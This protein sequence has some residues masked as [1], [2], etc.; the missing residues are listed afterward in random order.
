MLIYPPS[1]HVMARRPCG[2]A[3]PSHRLQAHLNKFHIERSTTLASRDLVRF[4][5]KEK[6]SSLLDK[7]LLDPRRET[8][9]FFELGREALARGQYTPRLWLQQPQVCI[10]G[11]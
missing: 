5:V 2:V 1:Y 11:H 8:V 7:P 6:M 10:Q 9:V 3:M 4:F